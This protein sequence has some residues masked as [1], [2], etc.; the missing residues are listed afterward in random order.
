MLHRNPAMKKEAQSLVIKVIGIPLSNLVSMIQ[1][2]T[3]PV[4]HFH[5]IPKAMD[6]SR[7]MLHPFLTKFP[8]PGRIEVG[9]N[10]PR[11]LK[12]PST[13][14]CP[15]ANKLFFRSP[16]LFP[17]Y[18]ERVSPTIFYIEARCTYTAGQKFRAKKES[19]F[20]LDL[21]TRDDLLE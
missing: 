4:I 5:S 8:R 7:A 3:I 17:L 19:S 16:A 10:R 15:P 14:D 20:S 9:H 1:H 11:R 12:R 2:L 13:I 18:F 21:A 6:L